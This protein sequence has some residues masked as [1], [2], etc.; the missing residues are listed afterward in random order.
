VCKSAY[1]IHLNDGTDEDDDAKSWV[2]YDLQTS[3]SISSSI[4]G[5]SRSQSKTGFNLE[6]LRDPSIVALLEAR[7]D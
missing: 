6:V 2:S 3:S 1:G 7:E 4:S 5:G